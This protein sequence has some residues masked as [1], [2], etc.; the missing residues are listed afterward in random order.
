MVFPN[1]FTSGSKI[2]FRILWFDNH[3]I[4]EGKVKTFWFTCHPWGIKSNPFVASYVIQKTLEDN[5][6]GLSDLTRDLIQKNNYMD[7]L[8]F[9][10]GN[11]DDARL[12]D[13]EAIELFDSRGFRLVKWSGNK[14]VVPVLS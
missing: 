5:V 1:R 13:N 7:D 3:D 8:I 6:T 12:I 14:E 10:A 4:G 11:L 2:L 9:S